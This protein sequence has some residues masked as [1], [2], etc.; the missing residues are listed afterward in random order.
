MNIIDCVPVQE[1][2][3]ALGLSG[4]STAI[5]SKQFTHNVLCF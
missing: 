1:I 4:S 2:Q 3:Q 5:S